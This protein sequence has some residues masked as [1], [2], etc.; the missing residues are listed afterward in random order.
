[1]RVG[2]YDSYIMF[3]DKTYFGLSFIVEDGSR[4]LVNIYDD[5]LLVFLK[6]LRM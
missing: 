4:S 2:G 1:M 6:E 5:K 3:D